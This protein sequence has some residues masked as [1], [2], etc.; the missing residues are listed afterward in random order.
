MPMSSENVKQWQRRSGLLLAVVLLAGCGSEAE[1]Y[2]D[3][4]TRMGEVAGS[5]AFQA[6]VAREQSWIEENRRLHRQLL[7]RNDN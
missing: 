7:R 6:C 5:P 2:A 4:C 3:R 1:W